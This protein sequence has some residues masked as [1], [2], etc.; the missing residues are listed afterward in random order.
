MSVKRFTITAA[1]PYANGPVHIGHLAGCYIPAD[2]YARYLRLTGQDV[3]FVCGSDEH[4]IPITIKA[5][6]EGVTPQEIVDRYH[7]M[8]RDAFKSFGI[9]FDVYSRTSSDLH[10]KTASEFF[11][12]LYRD[13]EL[14]EK[15][16][17]EFYDVDAGEFLADRYIS[18]TCPNCLNPGAYGDQCERCGKSLSPDELINPV[19]RLSGSVPVRK[20]TSHYYIDLGK[21][22]REWLKKWIES[23]KGDWKSTVYGQCMSWMG[24]GEHGLRPRAV[25]RD[26][27]WGVPVPAEVP[28]NEGKVLYVWFDAP[29][30]YISATKDFF[31][32]SEK[33]PWNKGNSWEDYWKKTGNSNLLHFIGKDN[34]VFHCIIFPAM[35]KAHGD[36]ILPENVPANEFLNLE[37]DKISTSRNWAVW[38]H[39]YLEDMPGREDELRYVLTANMPEAK[40][41]DFIWKYDGTDN[42]TDSFQAKVNN[43]LVNNLGNYVNRVVSLINKYYGGVLPEADP[44][45]V[46]LGPDNQPITQ[47]EFRRLFDSH[48]ASFH[49]LSKVN[50][51]P[52]FRQILRE[53]MDFSTMGN[54]FL[55]NNAPWGGKDPHSAEVRSTLFLAAQTAVYLAS[56]LG[57]FLPKTSAKIRGLLRLD[58]VSHSDSIL[59]HG[60]G[61]W[62]FVTSGHQIN[63]AEILFRRVED[64][65]IQKQLDRLTESKAIQL[66]THTISDT[67]K[68][69][70]SKEEI[71]Y[72]DFSKMDIRTGIIVAAEKIPKADKLLKL[73]VDT[74]IDV[75]TVL[76][77]ISMYYTPEEIVGEN[78]CI[79][80]NLAPRVMRGIESVGMILM[81]DGPDGKPVFL[82]ATEPLPPGSVIK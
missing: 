2:I 60:T 33:N 51:I 39:E 80:V 30:G 35:L 24:E 23:K 19:S 26:L 70:P 64:S 3:L 59:I 58:D 22:Q 77:G 41:N 31:K 5:R 73:T 43:E 4:G 55:Q 12:K 15:V 74:G 53:I 6:Q 32:N 63:P 76:S 52:S 69:T 82:K 44:I 34:I 11:L 68:V 28:D 61:V 37:G 45:I 81:A 54:R 27:N 25:T 79:L 8:M 40:D 72:D 50:S 46:P 56:C 36:F 16:S 65:D 42:T 14:L 38:L 20:S 47:D 17:D 21:H 7:S 29:I 49:S 71:N 10:K 13:G 18:G 1:L 67:P 57:P 48:L 62:P 75:R 66:S 9:H 78:V